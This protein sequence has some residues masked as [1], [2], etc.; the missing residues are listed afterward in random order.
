MDP[1]IKGGRAWPIFP[2]RRARAYSAGDTTERAVVEAPNDSTLLIELGT[3]LN[4]FPK[5]LAIMVT[6]VVAT[7]PCR[8]LAF[9]PG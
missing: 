6:A 9:A 5:L 1:A 2:V 4:I 7:D 8:I 3:P